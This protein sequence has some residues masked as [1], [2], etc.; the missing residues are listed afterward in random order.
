MQGRGTEPKEWKLFVVECLLL[1]NSLPTSE[2]LY[3]WQAALGTQLD[4][5]LSLHC[6]ANSI[7][8]EKG[9]LVPQKSE[10]NKSLG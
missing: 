3:A 8:F 2:S 1:A 9:R 6:Q 5:M 10:K 4:E 7:E